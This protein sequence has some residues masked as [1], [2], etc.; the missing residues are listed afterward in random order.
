[1]ICKD[2]VMVDPAKVEA[3][4]NWGVPKTPSEIGSFLGFA[5][6]YRRSIQNFV[7]KIACPLTK[8]TRKDVPYS[9]S[10]EQD[11]TFQV[12]KQLLC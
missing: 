10:N 5:G 8:L 9:W 12:W 4:M 7:S 3:V 1:M 6:Y 11:N 2:G